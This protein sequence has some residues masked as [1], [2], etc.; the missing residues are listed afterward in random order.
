MK[1]KVKAIRKTSIKKRLLTVPLIVIFLGIVSIGFI[2]SWS[3]RHSLLNQMRQDGLALANNVVR[4]IED[5]TMSLKTIDKMLEDKI[6]SAGKVVIAN[7]DRLSSDYLKNILKDLDVNE[8]YWYTP[9]GEIIYSTIDGYLGWVPPKGHPLYDF[10]LSSEQELMEDIREDAEFGSLVKYG[11]L[12]TTDGYL[13]QIGIKADEVQ[14]LTKKFSYQKLMEELATQKSAVYVTVIDTNKRV[15][16]HNNKDRIGMEIE[17]RN[18][19]K[20]IEN[21]ESYAFEYF[22]T[23]EN[24][25]VYNVTIPIF[26]DEEHIGSLNIGLCMEGVRAAIN[27]NIR[28]I[29]ISGIITFIILALLLGSLSKDTIKVIN[30]LKESLGILS[31]G[32]FTKEIPS[33]LL[34]KT[35]EFGEI[36]NDL[37]SMKKSIK[38]II[39]N[40]GD[41]SEQVAA[42]SEQLESTSH[43]VSIAAN[44]VA[45]T[46]EEIA[47]G[48]D[49]QA[50]QT[51]NGARSIA[52]LG[53]IIEENQQM[54]EKLN[55]ATK[56]VDEYKNKGIDTL[57]DLVGKTNETLKV[58]GKVREV[59]SDTNKSAEKIEN[60]SH[61]I[62]NIADQTNL[63]ALNAAIEAARAGE[64][65]RGF[66]V[67]ADEIRKL[68]EQSTNFTDEIETVIQNL[69][70][71]T[72]KA[73]VAMEEVGEI[74]TLQTEGVKDTK[75]KFENI[76]NA[77]E[78][79]NKVM[80]NLNYSGKHME[81]Q[82]EKMIDTIESLAAISEENAAATQEVASSVEEQ[83]A[84][85]IEIADSSEALT[86]L[87]EEMR[88][89]ILRFKY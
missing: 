35:N 75:N 4:Q 49:D 68:A 40:I 88:E 64:A 66:A 86:K 20:A 83:T 81:E 48:A 27:N 13:V 18:V 78:R 59:I 12:K 63:L 70:Q 58:T 19:V 32:D 67:V 50:K 11:A 37:D 42:S 15:I 44:E 7:R 89:N 74:V 73:V 51:E 85:M 82:K 21:K 65:G 43:Q 23:A 3:I 8:L 46:T 24:R 84:A 53:N 26:S 6:R 54:M 41:A 87:A 36:S 45:T 16:A 69:G 30:K 57:N 34:E 76:S 79:M 60:A 22:Y 55:I 56:E 38:A 80:E 17:D 29:T 62:K 25:N 9:E 28:T 77:I 72:E 10:K 31:L 14:K 1:K 47:K 52:M 39:R 33:E 71:K 5:N 2:S 61:M